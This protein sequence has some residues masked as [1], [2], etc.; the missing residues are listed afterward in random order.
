MKNY[1]ALIAAIAALLT[2]L[3]SLYKSVQGGKEAD[4]MT[5]SVFEVA[6]TQSAAMRERIAV[7]EA[8]CVKRGV[9][10]CHVDVDC[11]GGLLCLAGHCAKVA[12]AAPGKRLT[13]DVMQS[14]VQTKQRPLDLSAPDAPAAE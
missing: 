3:G 2:A 6:T 14:Y 7:L 4:L 10:E 12:A 1:A 8:T 9:E 11:G 5:R 13:Y